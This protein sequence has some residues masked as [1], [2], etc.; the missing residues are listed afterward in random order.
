MR[1]ART[2]LPVWSSTQTAWS[3]DAQSMPT[4]M[5]TTSGKLAGHLGE[6]DSAGWSVTGA[7]SVCRYCRSEASGGWSAAVSCWP[8]KGDRRWPT[9]QPHRAVQQDLRQPSSKQG[10]TSDRRGRCGLAGR[11]AGARPA[12]GQLRGRPAR[13]GSCGS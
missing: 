5:R 2:V 6:E 12:A 1:K 7:R 11:A 3:V 4:N 9:P 13:S 10:W 8:S